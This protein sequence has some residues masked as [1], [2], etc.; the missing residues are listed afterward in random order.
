MSCHHQHLEHEWIL[1]QNQYDS[2]EKHSLIIK[3]V[4]VLVCSLLLVHTDLDFITVGLCAL[5]WLID[6]IWKTFQNRIFQRL[7]VVEAGLCNEQLIE[8]KA[9]QLNT[10]WQ[11]QRGSPA[12][13]LME[14]AKNALVP[15]VLV[16]HALITALA[17]WASWLST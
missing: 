8:T 10:L 16:P 3:L 1:L 4:S 5:L 13:L 17:S 15:T 7:L 9:M 11:A 6:G 14:Y 2:Y 12:G